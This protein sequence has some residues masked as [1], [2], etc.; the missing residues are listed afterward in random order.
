MN[1]LLLACFILLIVCTGRAQYPL[2]YIITDTLYGV[3]YYGYG[4][5]S[6]IWEQYRRDSVR[7]FYSRLW[8]DSVEQIP[9]DR[10]RYGLYVL[11]DEDSAR[12]KR[13]LQNYLKDSADFRQRMHRRDSIR[14]YID[15]L[16][17][18]YYGYPI[19]ARAPL[20]LYIP[21]PLLM[22]FY[23]IKPEELG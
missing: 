7:G 17:N 12:Y 23:F 5:D 20:L 22:H 10:A 2:R 16:K 15:S 14:L 9:P 3:R 21:V 19:L 11:P 18:I 6:M 13:A 8:L 1:R 4:S